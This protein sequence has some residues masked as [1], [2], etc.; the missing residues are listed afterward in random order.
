MT[1][2]IMNSE[3]E[4]ICLSPG[5]AE[6]NHTKKLRIVCVM[7]DIVTSHFTNSSFKG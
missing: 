5:W 7:P 6:E 3:L 2:F 1:G 4:R